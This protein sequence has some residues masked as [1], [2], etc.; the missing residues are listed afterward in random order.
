MVNREIFKII[1][2]KKKVF[3]KDRKMVKPIQ[4]IPEDPRI[5]RLVLLSM[6]KIK[7]SLLKQFQLTKEE[8]KEY[9]A[10]LKGDKSKIEERLAKICKKDAISVGGR[11]I[12]E[13][14]SNADNS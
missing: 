11:L 12:K 10:A 13:V 3:Y 2:D 14:K 9:D 8:Q 1:I 5:R 6:N 7:G 4:M